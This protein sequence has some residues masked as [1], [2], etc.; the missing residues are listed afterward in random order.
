MTPLDEP[1]SR[2]RFGP[3]R[4]QWAKFFKKSAIQGNYTL[5]S[6]AKINNFGSQYFFC[7]ELTV[8]ADDD[9][10]FAL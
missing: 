5:L 9:V 2:E 8:A 6:T 1:Q 3:P 4:P 10:D 7:F